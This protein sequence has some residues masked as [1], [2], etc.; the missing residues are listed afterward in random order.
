MAKRYEVKQGDCI[1]SIAVEHGL[2]PDTVWNDAE[3][4][5]LKALRKDRNVLLPGDVVVVPDLRARETSAAADQRHT[6]KRKGVPTHLELRVLNEM[7]PVANASF[8]L[9]I[10]G[11]IVLEGMTGGDGSVRAPIPPNAKE[12]RLQIEDGDE[13]L[14]YDL[15]L[16]AV[17]PSEK[18]SGVQTRLENLGYACEPDAEDE[19]GEATEAALARF[20][21]DHGLKV[22]A[23]VDDATLAKLNDLHGDE[24]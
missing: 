24:A 19:L 15:T 12:G 16:G 4:A 23:A 2:L 17:N 20:Q 6:Y 21:C 14:I 1:D 9:E 11:R 8:I 13:Q 18:V 5:D 10:D 22:T 3:N 7:E